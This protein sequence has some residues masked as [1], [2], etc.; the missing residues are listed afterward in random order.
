MANVL[1][2]SGGTLFQPINGKIVPTECPPKY[3]PRH[4]AALPRP[5]GYF[6]VRERRSSDTE[7]ANPAQTATTSALTT[8]SRPKCWSKTPVTLAPSLL[9][10]TRRQCADVT[11]LT[12][13]L[14]IAGRNAAISASI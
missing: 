13:L 11:K 8:C 9:V 10:S 2:C 14:A 4:P 5:S 6:G 12:F 1:V 7:P 3:R